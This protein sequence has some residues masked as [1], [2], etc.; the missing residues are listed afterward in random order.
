[1]SNLS[2]FHLK[3]LNNLLNEGGYT[4]LIASNNDEFSNFFESFG[5]DIYKNY[6]NG[7]KGRTLYNFFQKAPDSDV[8]KVL[9][10]IRKII[11]F[12]YVDDENKIKRLNH[13]FEDI[14]K[15]LSNLTDFKGDS[16]IISKTNN[17]IRELTP[18]GFGDT[19]LIEDNILN[20]MFVLKKYRG[21]FISQ[22]DNEKFLEKFRNE[23]S[24][25]YDLNHQNIVRIYDYSKNDSWYI[26]EYIDGI[27]IDNYLKNKPTDLVS[28]FFQAINVFS[29]LES[30]KICHRDIRNT[31][32]LINKEGILKLIDFGFGKSINN[33]SSK[34]KTATKTINFPYTLPDEINS[35]T[36]KY[37]IK[38][39]IY[40]VG[41]LFKKIIEDNN[42]K[43]FPYNKILDNMICKNPEER[44][45]SFAYIKNI[46]KTDIK[47]AQ[48]IPSNFKENY[49]ELTNIL[50]NII[51]SKSENS[52]VYTLDKIID[53]LKELY[54][55][56]ILN[57]KLDSSKHFADCFISS[58]MEW[59]PNKRI[60]TIDYLSGLIK[61]LKSLNKTQ[62]VQI[63]KCLSFKLNNIK[64]Y[65]ELPF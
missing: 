56:N 25:L 35:D 6:D 41:K 62:Q 27:T 1:M 60:V 39:E 4:P 49:L 40:F 18:G 61:W 55:N 28:I 36:P 14:I 19:Y 46:I 15:S 64:V 20:K 44:A 22:A 31:N 26:M 65:E 53:N 24:M 16:I 32:I 57:E 45:E 23:I 8:L 13:L 48:I 63:S 30:K 37:N 21:E 17:K 50:D 58:I 10:E 38:T 11:N 59:Y 2:A 7:S 43:D 29:Y 3:E 52:M 5:I 47:Q 34:M 42:I 33:A 9:T 51:S 12:E 54:D